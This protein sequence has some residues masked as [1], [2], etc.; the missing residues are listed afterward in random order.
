MAARRYV[1]DNRGRF[2]SVGA[3]A[4]G[5]RL[6]TASGNKR[7]TQTKTIAGGKPVGTISKPK[8][9]KPGSIKPTV[10]ASPTPARLTPRQKARRLGALPQR[11]RQGPVR[12]SSI[13]SGTVGATNPVR[14]VSRVDRALKGVKLEHSSQTAVADV[15]RGGG[16]IA[17]VGPQTARRALISRPSRVSGIRARA[18]Y[19]D[20]TPPKLAEFIRRE[21]A[22]LAETRRAHSPRKRK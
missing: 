6:R 16:M 19:K 12:T 4:R 1:R 21:R 20:Y 9:L 5:G 7:A 8:G 15:F 3:T 2:A 14:N 13:P 17:S 18:A 10:A 22:T 11:Q